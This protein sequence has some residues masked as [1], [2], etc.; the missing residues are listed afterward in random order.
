MNRERNHYQPPAFPEDTAAF[1]A[2]GAS[3][4]ERARAMGSAARLAGESEMACPW[5]CG[6]GLSRAWLEGFNG[7]EPPAEKAPQ[8]RRQ[9]AQPQGFEMRPSPAA[10]KRAAARR[11]GRL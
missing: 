4:R 5:P 3:A 1:R 8:K 11:E 7:T 9:K 10:V 2:E 6:M